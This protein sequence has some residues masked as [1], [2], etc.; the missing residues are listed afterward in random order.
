MTTTTNDSGAPAVPQANGANG[1]NGASRATK[2]AARRL[3]LGMLREATKHLS[4]EAMRDGT[5]FKNL[6]VD[7]IRKH[8]AAISPATWEAAYPGLDAEARAGRHITAVARKASVA[9]ILASIGASTGELL[10]LV[11]EGLA[12]PVG[13]PAAMLSMAFEGAYTALLQIDLACDLASI[14]G[15]AFDPDDAGEIATLFAV[16]LGIQPRKHDQRPGP[17]RLPAE[18]GGTPAAK[19]SD[20]GH[21]TEGEG[22]EARLIDLEEGEVRNIVPFAGI[23]F[24]ARWNYLGTVLLGQKANRYIRYRR[25]IRRAFARVD[26]AGV[27]DPMLLVEGAWLLSTSDGEP[28]HE[29]LMAIALLAEALGRGERLDTSRARIEDEDE[30]LERVARSPAESHAALLDMLSLIAATDRE[31]Q[32]AERRLLR[33]VGKA[34]GRPVDFERIERIC[35]HLAD[36]EDLPGPGA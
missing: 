28:T 20:K 16:A 3:D 12:A 34:L 17:E 31:L 36:G 6:I 1:T 19:A 15:V 33:R 11:T 4:R 18:P 27:A 7:H 8:Q 22:L 5:W 29:E 30:W 26:C 35:R 10:A 24:S 32:T 23:V 2:E 21:A 13:V 14:H 25:A 9:G